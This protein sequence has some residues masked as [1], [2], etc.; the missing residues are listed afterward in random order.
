MN[1]KILYSLLGLAVLFFAVSL[2][3][4]LKSNRDSRPNGQLP[5]TSSAN[6]TA[7]GPV[8][9]QVRAFFFTESS[10][11]MQP[12]S[13]ELKLSGTREVKY[14]QFF[15]SLMK[16]RAGYIVPVPE[17]VTLRS[18]YL[19][20]AKNMM[21]VDFSDDLLNNF[22]SGTSSELEFIYFFVN[23]ICYNFR[24]IKKVKFLISGN[25]YPS[26]TGHL[27]VENPFFPDFTYLNQE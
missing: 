17:G 16:E 26:I 12:V 19:I 21:V 6:L 24:D 10:E 4:F 27:D 23:N 11:L 13:Y 20:D 1:K 9:M 5:V 7:E 2:F 25:E 22:P 18:V 15:D 3:I 8:T 14:R